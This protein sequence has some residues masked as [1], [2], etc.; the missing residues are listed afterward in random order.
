MRANGS[1]AVVLV[2]AAAL[3]TVGLYVSLHRVPIAVPDSR[4]VEPAFTTAKDAAVRRLT[5]AA[6]S[7]QAVTPGTLKGAL[8]WQAQGSCKAC[9]RRPGP[10][11][12]SSS[13]DT[14]RPITRVCRATRTRWEHR[15][16][17]T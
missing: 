10:P 6:F 5:H 4:S 3:A 17:W 11:G 16:D 2:T 8:H 14:S 7:L 9:R 15:S 13:C 1:V 12:A